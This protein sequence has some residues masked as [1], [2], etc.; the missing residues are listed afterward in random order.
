MINLKSHGKFTAFITLPSDYNHNEFDLSTIICEGARAM[1][2]QATPEFYIA[3]FNIQ[4]L[5]GI[6]PGAAVEFTVTGQLFDGTQFSG[7]D[8]VR[9]IS[10]G[11]I[12]L[13]VL[14]NP[15][16]QNKSVAINFSTVNL[17]EIQ[18]KPMI[19]KIYN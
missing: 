3:K 9:V 4:D 16:P 11:T 1:L 17:P 12:M 15:C 13:T 8:I 2:G 18:T 14:P 6:Q 7:S 19:V 5:V 10:P